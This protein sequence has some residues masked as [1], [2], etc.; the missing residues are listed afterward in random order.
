MSDEPLP[1]LPSLYPVEILEMIIFAE[2][3]DEAM[4]ILDYYNEVYFAKSI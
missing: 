1:L 2:T 3:D 4:N